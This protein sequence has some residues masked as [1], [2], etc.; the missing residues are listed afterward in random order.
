MKSWQFFT[1]RFHVTKKYFQ[2][3]E[4]EGRGITFRRTCCSFKKLECPMPLTSNWTI[5][6]HNRSLC[7]ILFPHKRWILCCKCF[8]SRD[9]WTN[10]RSVQVGN[11]C[12]I[13]TLCCCQTC[14]CWCAIFRAVR[15]WYWFEIHT[16]RDNKKV[17][18][19]RGKNAK[20]MKK[21]SKNYF[22]PTDPNFF[23]TWN[24]NHM[25]FFSPYSNIP[26]RLWISV[27]PSCVGTRR[28]SWASS[29]YG[30]QWVKRTID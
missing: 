25:Y 19:H 6:S 7:Q 26:E 5:R 15:A 24:R 27:P 22:R 17:E 10:R 23:T 14:Q 1:I 30:L 11:Y 3:N 2:C 18:I 9:T 16:Q 13:C 21:Y 28:Y 8:C 12:Y 29:I 20:T 4:D